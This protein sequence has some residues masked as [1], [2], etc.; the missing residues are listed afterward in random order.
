MSAIV[1]N[2]IDYLGAAVG[3]GDSAS[4]CQRAKLVTLSDSRTIRLTYAVLKYSRFSC[5][6]ASSTIGSYETSS[7]SSG[8][9]ESSTGAAGVGGAVLSGSELDD[10]TR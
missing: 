4:R 10:S 6:H 2:F 3:C 8:R 7:L 5:C 1:S 9:V